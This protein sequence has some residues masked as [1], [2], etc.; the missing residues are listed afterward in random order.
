MSGQRSVSGR[1]SCGRDGMS[2]SKRGGGWL[3]GRPR[4]SIRTRLTLWYLALFAVTGGVMLTVVYL[5]TWQALTSSDSSLAASIAAVPGVQATPAVAA[6]PGLNV[7]PAWSEAELAATINAARRAA[8]RDIVVRSG[9][10]FALMA[11][12]AA[13]LC[14][15]LASRA[16]QPLRTVTETAGRLSHETLDSRIPATGPQD[17][18]RTL[19][20]AFNTML[21]RLGRAFQAQRL[22]AANASHELRTPLT[23]IQTAAEKALSRPNRPEAD[24]RKALGTV[25]AAAHRSERLL[26]S[27]LVLA[28]LGRPDRIERPEGVDG[29]DLAAAVASASVAVRRTGPVVYEQLS[30]A[31]TGAD[32]VLVE[33]L[34]TA[35]RNL[36]WPTRGRRSAARTCR[37]SARR[38]SAARTAPAPAARGWAWPSWM[39]SSAPTT[40]P[41]RPPRARAAASR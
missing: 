7:V 15:L 20:E 41:G 30:P 5:L 16:L 14:W 18:I 38:S 32:P 12:L 11:S 1:S 6:S 31:P 34:G 2:G 39:R 26:S 24:Y 3:T 21:D 35:P 19:T 13:G 33:L 10:V 17:E 8:L 23:I 36:S 27:L 40:A 4:L 22:F 9:A 37:N 25:V 28:R 29:V